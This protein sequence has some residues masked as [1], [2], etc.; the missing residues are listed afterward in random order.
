[1]DDPFVA[2][3]QHPNAYTS[4]NEMTIPTRANVRMPP[5]VKGTARHTSTGHE[6]GS[7]IAKMQRATLRANAHPMSNLPTL[8]GQVTK[9]PEE[10][11]E[12]RAMNGP[13]RPSLQ[14]PTVLPTPLNGPT[15]Q[16]QVS[17]ATPRDPHPYTGFTAP[18]SKTQM[19]MQTVGDTYNTDNTSSGRT[20]L[21][22]PGPSQLTTRNTSLTSTSNGAAG[23]HRPSFLDLTHGHESGYEDPLN[24]STTVKGVYHNGNYVL[25][26]AHTDTPNR[27]GETDQ[28][29]MF[30]NTNPPAYVNTSSHANTG[31]VSSSSS[32]E[33][34]VTRYDSGFSDYDTRDVELTPDERAK[35]DWEWFTAP[36][37]AAT[38]VKNV[39][40]TSYSHL[41]PTHFTPITPGSR[42]L[43]IPPI[44]SGRR[45]VHGSGDTSAIS[46]SR[47]SKPEKERLRD[48]Q[49]AAVAMLAPAISNMAIHR[50]NDHRNPFTQYEDP[51]AWCVDNT[52]TS[53]SSF[54]GAYRGGGNTHHA[55]NG[56]GW[57]YGGAGGG[58]AQAGGVGGAGAGYR[59]LLGENEWNPPRRVGRDP[60]YPVSYLDGRVTR[61]EDVSVG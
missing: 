35:R 42:N 58:G 20:V 59:S 3:Y 34:S 29:N 44:G 37:P 41:A 12:I 13:R 17:P 2:Q 15:T 19:L 16:D 47:D 11:A 46:A 26:S 9:R 25:R 28:A 51:P 33:A 60:R 18:A 55:G 23:N 40:E 7:L 22:D 4:D 24:T 8:A 54:T 57:G 36:N 52:E 61:F 27:V 31:Q 10:Y 50:D 30:P 6:P 53:P 14:T 49:A 45:G 38:R 1:M 39:I 48:E 32:S 5:A 21:Y 56:A 43:R